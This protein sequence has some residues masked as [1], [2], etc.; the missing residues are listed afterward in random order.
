MKRIIFSVCCICIGVMA[1]AQN[2]TKVLNQ[3]ISVFDKAPGITADYVITAGQGSSSG[4]IDMCGNKFRIVSDDM[5]CWYDGTS[6]WTYSTISEEVSVTTP[7]LEEMQMSNP[8]IAIK[9]LKKTCNIYKAFTQIEGFYTLKL[10]PKNDQSIKQ[11]LVYLENGSYNVSKVYFEMADGNNYKTVISN[12]KT[13]KLDDGIFN[14][15]RNMVPAG[16]EVVDL[17]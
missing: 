7:T 5:I 12:Y 9:T 13:T 10:V 15:D 16:T 17:R 2:A 3:A 14:Y 4:K 6:Q 8:Y 11:I 1:F